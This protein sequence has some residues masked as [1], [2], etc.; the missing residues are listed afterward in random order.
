M[1]KNNDLRMTIRFKKDNPEQ[2]E[3]YNKLNQRRIATKQPI[4]TMV[5]EALDMYF[6]RNGEFHFGWEEVI[7]DIVHTEVEKALRNWLVSVTLDPHSVEN[8]VKDDD[9]IDTAPQD[10]DSLI[11]G[12]GF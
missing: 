5:M 12:L 8:S 7:R 9:A 6:Q 3:L 10:L 11:A 2:C 1:E 4:S